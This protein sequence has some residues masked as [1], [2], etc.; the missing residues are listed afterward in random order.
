MVCYR[1]TVLEIC[2]LNWELKD[3][4]TAIINGYTKLV[5]KV[6]RSDLTVKFWCPNVP[7]IL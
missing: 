1:R 5:Y 3:N 4:C 7:G 6:T 2:P